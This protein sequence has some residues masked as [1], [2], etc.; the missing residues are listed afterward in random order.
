M[1]D[2]IESAITYSLRGLSDRKDR[3]SNNIA[4]IQTPGYLADQT[5]FES[6][7]KSALNGNGSVAANPVHRK[8]LAPTR[9]DG[10]NVDLDNETMSAIQTELRY[11]TMIEAMN[12][13]FKIMRSAIG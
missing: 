1:T 8:S 9:T 6:A 13:K 5:D 2:A 7:L 4:N 10:N 12:T 3:I 11:K